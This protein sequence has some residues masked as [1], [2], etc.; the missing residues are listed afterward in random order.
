M[1]CNAAF[2]DYYMAKEAAENAKKE[3][4]RNEACTFIHP[5]PIVPLLSH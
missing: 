5:L 2:Q 3:R 1:Y 4:H